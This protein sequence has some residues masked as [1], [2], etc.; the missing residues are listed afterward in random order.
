MPDWVIANAWS[1]AGV[2]VGVTAIGIAIVI[3]LVQR[4]IK[5]VAFRVVSRTQLV[6]A[7]GDIPELDVSFR[8]ERVTDVQVIEV[9]VLNTGNI[10][11]ATADY[12]RAM[13]VNFGA[14][15]SVLTAEV[16]RAHPRSLR[17]ACHPDGSG[18]VIEPVMLN[19]GDW[20]QVKTLVSRSG[21]VSVDS[22][23]IGVKDVTE[24]TEES[25]SPL[26][27]VAA[28]GSVALGVT[29]WFTG[30]THGSL[31]FTIAAIGAL[32]AGLALTYW[33]TVRYRRQGITGGGFAPAQLSPDIP[34]QRP[35][36][37]PAVQPI[38]ARPTPV[39]S[40]PHVAPSAPWAPSPEDLDVALAKALEAAGRIG[41][42]AILEL[43]WIDIFPEREVNFRGSS[44]LADRYFMITVTSEG[45][46]STFGVRRLGD[47]NG[48]LTPGNDG[49]WR[50][51]R[52]WQDLVNLSWFR[53]QPFEGSARLG[54]KDREGGPRWVATYDSR[55]GL[56]VTTCFEIANEKLV[57]VPC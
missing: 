44:E 6:G 2:L 21:K 50:A 52:G 46:I 26:R 31:P 55:A 54:L 35:A 22:R 13:R 7:T 8:G 57:E 10:A 36:P 16:E 29:F 32:T 56:W 37:T 27:V 19:G 51:V 40:R 43:A 49:P 9:R 48:P 42:D 17:I 11:I 38:A 23:I 33:P 24:R 39:A 3:A 20:I 53:V 5:R 1:I 4:T 25:L 12:E 34:Q 14:G 15:A 47:S 18:F 30:S 28:L 41:P 45:G